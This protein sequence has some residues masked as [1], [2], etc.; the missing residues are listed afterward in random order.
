MPCGRPC[1][2]APHVHGLTDAAAGL[3]CC[4]AVRKSM[5]ACTTRPRWTCENGTTA[6]ADGDFPEGGWANRALGCEPQVTCSVATTAYSGDSVIVCAPNIFL[7]PL[8][9]QRRKGILV[10]SL[11]RRILHRRNKSE[12]EKWPLFSLQKHHTV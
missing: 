12:R 6:P 4:R 1:R 11:V 2:R 10:P 3:N 9:K 7:L 5:V 8:E